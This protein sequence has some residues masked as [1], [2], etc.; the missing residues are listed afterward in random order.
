M[1]DHESYLQKRAAE[2]WDRIRCRVVPCRKGARE[3]SLKQGEY[4]IAPTFW[5]GER[6][7]LV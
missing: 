5:V 3:G 6:S 1:R 2:E 4:G 7:E